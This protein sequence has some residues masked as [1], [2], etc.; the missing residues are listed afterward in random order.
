MSADI[1]CIPFYAWHGDRINIIRVSLCH[2]PLEVS[3][4]V[5]S[6]EY[7]ERLLPDLL[8]CAE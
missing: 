8:K 6:S 5:A 2:A 3:D 7:G 1:I 4:S